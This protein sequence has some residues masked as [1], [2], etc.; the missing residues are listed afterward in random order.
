MAEQAYLADRSLQH[1]RISGYEVA[2][3]WKTSNVNFR[4]QE[5]WL[6]DCRIAKTC[7]R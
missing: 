6:G 4:N 2:N 3:A 5:L 7:Y 1:Y